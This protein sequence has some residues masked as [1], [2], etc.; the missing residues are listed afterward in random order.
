MKLSL[1]KA[2][3]LPH[4]PWW[5][6]AIIVLW[7]I[8]VGGTEIAQH[9][10]HVDVSLCAFKRLTGLPC[11]S[12]GSTRAAESLLAGHPVRAWLY[13]PLISTVV[14][15]AGAV[16]GV[17][18]VAARAVRLDMSQREIHAATLLLIALVLINWAYLIVRGC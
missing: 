10:A 14:A 13:N 4:V 2:S 18:L 1:V 8:L 6:V 12:C 5:A 9:Y 3:R 17:R 7:L 15:M 11:P 16:L